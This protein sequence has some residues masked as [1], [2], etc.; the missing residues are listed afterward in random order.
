VTRRDRLW[1]TT[2]TASGSMSTTLQ[3]P[4]R[5]SGTSCFPESST[6]SAAG[7][8]Q[9]GLSPGSRTRWHTR[10]PDG[11]ARHRAASLTRRTGPTGRTRRPRLRLRPTTLG[12]VNAQLNSRPSSSSSASLWPLRQRTARGAHNEPQLEGMNFRFS[13][14]LS[15]RE[16]L[17]GKA[18]NSPAH[19]H[20]RC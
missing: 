2:S 4:R 16:H 9:P 8:S 13:G 7:S 17:P 10:R 15:S 18:A 11:A 12:I 14:G 6:G 20:R 1:P 5:P 19:A 3:S